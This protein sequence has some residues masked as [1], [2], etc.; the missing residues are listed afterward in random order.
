L[1]LDDLFTDLFGPV[2]PKCKRNGR[3]MLPLGSGNFC[4]TVEK[5]SDFFAF[6]SI[7][8]MGCWMIE[9]RQMEG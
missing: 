1:P 9:A 2:Q 4:V 6:F 7:S 8:L 3:E 5:K